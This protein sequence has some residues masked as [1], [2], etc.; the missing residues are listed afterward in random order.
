M[1]T[2]II[3]KVSPIVAIEDSREGRFLTIDGGKVFDDVKTGDSVAV[4]GVC[5]TAITSIKPHRFQV[6][7]ESLAVTTLGM[8]SRGNFVN[9]ETAVKA[10]DPMGGHFV[11]GHVDARGKIVKL[12][13]KAGGFSLSVEFEPKWDKY[14]IYKGSIAIDGISLTVNLVKKGQA[15]IHLLPHTF[16]NTNLRFRK[17]GEWVNLEFD[18]L[19]KY[20]ERMVGRGQS[21][22]SDSSQEVSEKFLR[23]NGFIN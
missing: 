13:K 2:G 14:I 6:S 3:E 17:G 1:F 22:S 11:Q 5:L 12:A 15:E 9:I 20:I 7:A 18:M 8:L 23:E 4:N 10:G 19:A 21:R 16:E